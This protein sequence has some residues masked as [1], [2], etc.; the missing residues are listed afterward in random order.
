MQ[1]AFLAFLLLLLAVAFGLARYRAA[2][3]RR[4]TDQHQARRTQRTE[5]ERRA[6]QAL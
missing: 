3:D 4:R 5:V 6:R 2:R 1:Y